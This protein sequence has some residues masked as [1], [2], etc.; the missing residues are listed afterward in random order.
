MVRSKV[1]SRPTTMMSVQPD[2]VR[3]ENVQPDPVGAD[4]VPPFRPD[5]CLA[6]VRAVSLRE[7]SVDDDCRT[8][9]KMRTKMMTTKLSPSSS[10]S[11]M[12]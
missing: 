10:P 9:T 4:N 1:R 6:P 5:E 2:P 7:C 12:S 8:R 3:G 11:R